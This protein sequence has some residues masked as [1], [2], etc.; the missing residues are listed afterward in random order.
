MGRH[1][2]AAKAE[3]QQAIELTA[4]IERAGA[5]LNPAPARRQARVIA[6]MILAS[7]Q[8][9]FNKFDGQPQKQ[10][11][12]IVVIDHDG[13][14]RVDHDGGETF[15]QGGGARWQSLA[16]FAGAES[17]SLA[18]I[19]PEPVAELQPGVEEGTVGTGNPFTI[20]LFMASG[21]TIKIRGV[22]EFGWRRGFNGGPFNWL[23]IKQT[24]DPT[25]G[26]ILVP[27][28]RLSDIVGVMQLP[29]GARD[30]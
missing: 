4:A 13:G 14:V 12:P 22:T 15:K 21:H 17:R 7:D 6:D 28:L 2:S 26:R 16:L 10:A 29:G 11:Y 8:A 9:M 24:D 20:L 25:L 23:Q 5:L 19:E 18:N 30:A 3:E 1:T 27:T